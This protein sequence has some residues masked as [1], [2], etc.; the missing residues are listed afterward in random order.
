MMRVLHVIG[1]MDRGGAETMIMNLYRAMDRTEVQFDFLV[2]EERECDYDAEIL[3]LGGRI[4]RAPRFNGVN[5]YAYRR[6]FREL[7]ETHPEW[8]V[9]HGHIGSSAALY[10]T[11]AK[12][13]GRVA[14]AHS[15]AQN[16]MKGL[17]CLAF[18][19]LSYPT[20]N[21]ADWF[22]GCSEEA[23]VDRFGPQVAQGERCFVLRNGIDL[24]RYAFDDAVRARM[25]EELGVRSDAPV[26]CHVGRFT[27]V[28]NHA[29][30][31][32]VFS[33]SKSEMPDAVLLLAGRGELEDEIRR[34][35]DAR[36]LADAVKFLGVR[37]DIC[38]VLQAA[39]VF[40]FPSR[41]EGLAI[42]VV[43]AQASGL[44][45]L[46]ST[47]VPDVAVVSK[48]VVH[49]DLAEGAQRWADLA[50]DLACGS[51]AVDRSR[52]VEEVRASGFGIEESAKWLDG[53]YRSL[54]SGEDAS[55]KPAVR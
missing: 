49:I 42:A 43:E 27:E 24:S 10:L 14:I 32:D 26:F 55:V 15:H 5:Y 48:G 8:L 13:A 45:G 38:D 39:D 23:C 11:E 47:G 4:F 33:L 54:A 37:D 53:F 1:A 41:K 7:F 12:R 29:F 21:I 50:I 2:H 51:Q 34:N 31:L 18:K 35:V 19:V 44:P 17:P 3:S 28:K 16:Y 52:G 9:V 25:R 6:V 40:V 46:V 22:L 36:G 20:R 30:L